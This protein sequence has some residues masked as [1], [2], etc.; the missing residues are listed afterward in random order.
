[1]GDRSDVQLSL[2]FSSDL[3]KT[4]ASALSSLTLADFAKANAARTTD[5]WDLHN[6]YEKAVVDRCYKE[7][8]PR[9]HHRLADSPTYLRD[10]CWAMMESV[11]VTQPTENS[12]NVSA[13]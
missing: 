12:S 6:E 2:E 3:Y 1:L 9:W 5:K 4:A 11:I 10:N 8:L 13:K 7:L